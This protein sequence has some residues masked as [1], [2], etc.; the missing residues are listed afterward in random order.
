MAE[1]IL[2]MLYDRTANYGHDNWDFV[3]AFRA[4]GKEPQIQHAD[5]VLARLTDRGW[6][7]ADKSLRLQGS[8]SARLTELGKRAA[9]DALDRRAPKSIDE[10]LRRVSRSDWIAIAAFVVSLIALFK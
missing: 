10:R 2:V 9:I 8:F 6:L 4:A 7:I 3:S 1:D 5:D